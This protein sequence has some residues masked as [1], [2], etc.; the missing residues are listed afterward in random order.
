ML[1]T[2]KVVTKSH[3]TSAVFLPFCIYLW[4]QKTVNLIGWNND[5]FLYFANLGQWT[6]VTDLFA[7]GMPECW[8]ENLTIFEHDSVSSHIWWICLASSVTVSSESSITSLVTC[9]SLS[10]STIFCMARLFLQ[11]ESCW[12]TIIV[13]Q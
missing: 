10:R 11:K 4:T 6:C 5:E 8:L 3:S 2:T 7:S 9:L 13:P 12:V 1:F